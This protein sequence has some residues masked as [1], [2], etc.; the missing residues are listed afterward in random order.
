MNLSITKKQK[1]FIDSTADETLYGGAAGGGKSYG[2][3]I[4]ALLFALKYPGSR[5]LILRRTFPELK[6]SLILVSYQIFPVDI[7]KYNASDHVWIFTNGSIVEFGYCDTDGDVQKYQSAEYDVIRFDELTHF[8]EFQYTYLISRIRGANGYP[9]QVKATTNPGSEGH[10]W[11][12]ARFIDVAEPGAVYRDETGRTRVFIPALVHENRF[13]MDA[14]PQYIQRLE[15]LP[16]D[17]RK[18]LLDGEWNLFVGQYF[19]EFRYEKHVVEPFEL[20]QHW[21]RFVSIDWGYN[22]PCAVYWH[23][24]TQD[25]RIYTYREYY[26][27][28]R[29]AKQVAESILDM[30]NGEK[31]DYVVCSPDMWAKRGND[32]VHGESIAETMMRCGLPL[33]KAD[34]DRINGWMRMHEY[35]ADAPDGKPYWQIFSTCRNL[36]RTLPALVHDDTKVEDV[37]DKSEDHAAE[38]CRYALMSRPSPAKVPQPQ[39]KPIWNFEKHKPDPFRNVIDRS[40]IDY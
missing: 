24:I 35:L 22:D 26:Q 29:T 2:Q 32:A 14:D 23:A 20:E 1:Q 16:G 34:N 3:L 21:K 19:K 5:Q 31:I 8:T 10:A 6:R 27:N 13:L 17:Q 33:I 9:K 11:V 38:S 36:I 39:R 25:S 7:C 4:D 12:K 28:Q 15:Q 40:Y 37:S 18:A 30:S